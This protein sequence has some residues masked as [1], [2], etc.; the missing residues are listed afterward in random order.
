MHP[1]D[2]FVVIGIACMMGITPVLYV[3]RDPILAIGYLVGSTVGALTGSHIAF[4]YYPQSDKFGIILGGLIG[5]F[6]PV[7]VW[8]LVRKGKD[9]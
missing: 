7:A 6:V 8:H 2:F 4:W 3:K 1:V 5:A 9:K